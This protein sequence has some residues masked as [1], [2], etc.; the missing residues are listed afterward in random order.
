MTC[1]SGLGSEEMAW[2]AMVVFQPIFNEFFF[3][4][5]IDYWFFAN[6]GFM[7]DVTMFTMSPARKVRK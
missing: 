5:I 4:R 1:E 7:L 3:T 2:M 6:F